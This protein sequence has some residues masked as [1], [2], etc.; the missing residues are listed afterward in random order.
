LLGVGVPLVIA[1]ALG[2]CAAAEQP[3]HPFV[4]IAELEINP[5][6][7][8]GYKAAVKEEIQ[9]SLSVEPG[10]VAIYC[11][12]EADKPSSLRFFEVYVDETAYKAHIGSPHFRKYADTTRHMIRSR[13]LIDTVPV[14]LGTRQ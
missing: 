9:T 3:R 12:A 4:R 11:V 2:G 7:L 8:D 13:R 1:L 10:V 14:V 5:E 6:H